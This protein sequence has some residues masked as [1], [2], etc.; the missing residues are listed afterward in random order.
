[1]APVPA[2]KLGSFSSMTFGVRGGYALMLSGL[3]G[4]WPRAGISFVSGETE[5]ADSE[6]QSSIFA[7]C[8]ELPLLI[9]PAPHV[10]FMVG[11]TIDFTVAGSGDAEDAAGNESEVEDL[12]VNT[13]GVQAG[14][15]A[16]F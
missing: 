2:L 4:I 11:P 6:L 9:V 15:I 14:I 8:A 12:R 5:Q 7:L 16:W 3:L 10:A 13:V 1:L